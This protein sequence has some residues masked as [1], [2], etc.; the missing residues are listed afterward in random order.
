MDTN[1]DMIKEQQTV[2]PLPLMRSDSIK[3]IALALSK[4]QGEI[5]GAIK[6]SRNQYAKLYA[7]LESMQEATREPLCKYELS[8]VNTIDNEIEKIVVYAHLLHS[9]GEFISSRLTMTPGKKPKK[10]EGGVDFIFSQDPQCIKAAVTYARTILFAALINLVQ[11]DQEDG[12]NK[13]NTQSQT[14]KPANQQSSQSN[15][16]DH[17]IEDKSAKLRKQI[18]EKLGEMHGGDVVAMDTFLKAIELQDGTKPSLSSI[19]MFE[20]SSLASILNQIM[21]A[22]NA[23]KKGESLNKA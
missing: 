5:K 19:E 4:A 8:V 11:V 12:Q 22:Y 13:N 21:K 15:G 3:N 16:S 9:S 10:E 17:A 14:Q 23:W 7:D 2:I 18:N 6:D 20:V 1:M